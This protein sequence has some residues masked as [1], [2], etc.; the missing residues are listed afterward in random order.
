MEVSF[1]LEPPDQ[2]I[3]L[4]GKIRNHD[5]EKHQKESIRIDDPHHI[6]FLPPFVNRP[7]PIHRRSWCVASSTVPIFNDFL[8]P[9]LLPV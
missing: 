4:N 8:L 2:H 6:H 1:P 3:H 7:L 5:D 9:V